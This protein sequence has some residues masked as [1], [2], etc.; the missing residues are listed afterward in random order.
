M[1]SGS[2][3]RAHS[4]GRKIHFDSLR[5]TYASWLVEGGV[6]LYRVKELMGH[7][8]IQTTMRY[9]H[10]APDNLRNEVERVFG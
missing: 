8:S 4:G 9:A 2:G 1:T 3:R 10:L 7:A 6:D 5:H